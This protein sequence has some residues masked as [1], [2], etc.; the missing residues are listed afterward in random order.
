ML[1]F[2]WQISN[3]DEIVFVDIFQNQLLNL[4]HLISCHSPKTCNSSKRQKLDLNQNKKKFRMNDSN[5]CEIC[6]NPLDEKK[7][8]KKIRKTIKPNNWFHPPQC[9]IIMNSINHTQSHS[10]LPHSKLKTFLIEV[11]KKQEL[12]KCGSFY[13][14]VLGSKVDWR[15]VDPKLI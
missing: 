5:I 2:C 12:F 8:V 7:T 4:F 1:L 11:N 14:T 13:I 15:S 3:L 9:V 10:F 6:L